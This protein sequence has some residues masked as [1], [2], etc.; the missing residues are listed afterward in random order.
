MVPGGPRR[1]LRPFITYVSLYTT[2]AS[3]YYVCVP[4]FYVCVPLSF[5]LNV[6]AHGG[7]LPAVHDVAAAE[8]VWFRVWGAG[9]RV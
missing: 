7:E 8:E 1:G 5:S 2:F 9:F 6:Q 4:L 3:L